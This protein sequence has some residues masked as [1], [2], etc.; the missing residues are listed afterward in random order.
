MAAW[1]PVEEERHC[2]QRS[3]V[4]MHQ[5]ICIGWRTIRGLALLGDTA[6]KMNLRNTDGRTARRPAEQAMQ[7]PR[8]KL[9]FKHCLVPMSIPKQ[10]LRRMLWHQCGP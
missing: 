6:C 3:G 9:K 5:C 1:Q 10:L 4:P 2:K 8:P 7:R